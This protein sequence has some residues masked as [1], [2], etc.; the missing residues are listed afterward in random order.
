MTTNIFLN[1]YQ[2][3]ENKLTYNFFAILEIL[4]SNQFIDY[5]TSKQTSE[6]PIIG[7]KT[8]YGGGET[9]PDGSFDIKLSNAKQI[10]VFYEN[11][12]NR[13]GLDADQLIGH[14][15][16]CSE[17]DLLLVTSPRKSDIEIVK[18]IGDPRIVFRTWQEISLYLKKNFQDNPIVQQFVEYGKKSG[19]FDELGEI[20]SEEIQIYCEYLKINF[21]LKISSI[22]QNFIH[23]I[24]FSKFGFNNIKLHYSDAWGRK[25]AEI[26]LKNTDNSTYEQFGAI[27]LYYDI[28][29]H[30]IIFKKNLPELA[31]FFDIDPEHKNLLQ[32]DNEFKE[33]KNNLVADGFESNLENELTANQWRLLAYRQTISDFKI[34]NVQEIISFTEKVLTIILKN[35]ATKHKYFSQ[36]IKT[37]EI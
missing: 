6:K 26:S 31:F 8:V 19:E 24:D 5:L 36:F 2:Q 33:I 9:N 14:L 18:E 37:E 16:Q 25:G 17:S 15:K 1:S 4:N 35:N 7:I 23:D 28:D 13:R 27:C 11:K 21:D 12:T 32:I 3:P 30:G 29:D 22:F 10:T 20:Y 34:L